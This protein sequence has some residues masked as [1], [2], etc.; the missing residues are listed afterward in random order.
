MIHVYGDS[1]AYMN[2]KNLSIPY[3]DHH[4]SNITMYRIGRDNMII[5]FNK[6]DH[7]EHSIICM[8]Y[9]EIDCRCHIQKQINLGNDEDAIIR[10]LVDRYITTIQQHVIHYR[11]IILVGVIPPTKQIDYETINGPITHEYPFVGS[12]ENR[13]RYT[14]KLNELL[15]NRCEQYDFIYFNPHMGYT[16]DDGTLQYER[17]DQTVHLGDNSIFLKKFIELYESIKQIP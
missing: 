12:D 4:K 10:E 5:N 14:Y 6:D 13:V 1:H 8:V 9:G 11:K 15:E 16:R 3:I 7:N 17:S 2:F